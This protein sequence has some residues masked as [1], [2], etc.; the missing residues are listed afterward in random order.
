MSSINKLHSDLLIEIFYHTE[1]PQ[2]TPSVCKKWK[3][4][5]ELV[6]LSIIHQIKAHHQEHSA[7]PPNIYKILQAP[8]EPQQLLKIFRLLKR[9][10]PELSFGI[11]LANYIKYMQAFETVQLI[12]LMKM[13]PQIDL[14]LFPKF[15]STSEKATYLS[16]IIKSGK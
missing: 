3:T 11:S 15:D 10:K 9:A 16:H 5:Q 13:L 8:A 12:R 1:S 7:C 4:H 14:L 6:N 2:V